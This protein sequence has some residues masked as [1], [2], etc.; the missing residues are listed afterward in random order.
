MRD[1]DAFPHSRSVPRA[2]QLFLVGEPPRSATAE[3]YSD[4]PQDQTSLRR[5]LITKEAGLGVLM[6]IA[7][8]EAVFIG[9][10]LYSRQA[11]DAAPG[12]AS[13]IQGIHRNEP[14]PTMAKLKPVAERAATSTPMGAMAEGARRQRSGGFR[15]SSPIEIQVLEGDRVLGSSTTGPIVMGAGRHELDFINSAFGYRSRQQVEIKANEI[16][17]LS[18]LP[19]AGRVNINVTPWAQVWIDGNAAGETPLANLP[20]SVGEHRIILRHPQLGERTGTFIVRPSALTRFSATFDLA[21]STSTPVSPAPAPRAP[22]PPAAAK[23]GSTSPASTGSSASAAPRSSAPPS[24]AKSIYGVDDVDVIGP[25][26][27]S[28]RFP[29]WNPA[30][31]DVHSKFKGLLQIVVDERGTVTNAEMQISAHPGYDADLV[32]AARTWT[33]KPASREGVPVSYLKLLDITLNPPRA[34]K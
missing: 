14:G 2:P 12:N 17:N 27:I 20:M 23:S 15:L 21:A 25:I 30:G 9:V 28:T 19:P 31:H 4:A 8:L 1:T 26:A 22:S 16:F 24:P 18:V 6:G 29:A 33:F 7:F 13:D 3:S 32:Q 11:P 10:L 5:L 34:T